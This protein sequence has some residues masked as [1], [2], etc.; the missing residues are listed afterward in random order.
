MPR[1]E[2]EAAAEAPDN[3]VNSKVSSIFGLFL[4]FLGFVLAWSQKVM[5]WKQTLLSCQNLIFGLF[6]PILN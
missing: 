3:L 4:E 2:D 6:E 1:G 5:T